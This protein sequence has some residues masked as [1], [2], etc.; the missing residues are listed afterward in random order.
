MRAIVA[1][2]LVL[3]PSTAW[4]QSNQGAVSIT[5]YDQQAL[6][7]DTRVPAMCHIAGR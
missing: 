7:E 3:V 6:V 5:I 4:A 2:V 1:A